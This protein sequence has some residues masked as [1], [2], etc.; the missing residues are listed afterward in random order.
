M[1]YT[2]AGLEWTLSP[3][4]KDEEENYWSPAQCLEM[5]KSCMYENAREGLGATCKTEYG[6]I[7]V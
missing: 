3:A 4:S 7:F 6:M 2:C 5:C 1:T